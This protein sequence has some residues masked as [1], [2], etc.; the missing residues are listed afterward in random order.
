MR[1]LLGLE[2]FGLRRSALV[3]PF[4]AP[5]RGSCRSTARSARRHAARSRPVREAAHA[6]LYFLRLRRL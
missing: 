2:L 1:L 4:R 6:L 3:M 5:T